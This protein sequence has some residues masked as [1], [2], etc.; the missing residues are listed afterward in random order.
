MPTV[1]FLPM[2]RPSWNRICRLR[3]PRHSMSDFSFF[4]PLAMK[5]LCFHMRLPWLSRRLYSRFLYLCDIDRKSFTEYNL[6]MLFL[7]SFVDTG[8]SHSTPIQHTA[9]TPINAATCRE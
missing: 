8:Y 5:S 6:N 4:P 1:L 3:S 7:N 2:V 9:I